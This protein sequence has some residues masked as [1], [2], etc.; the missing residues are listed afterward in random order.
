MDYQCTS[1][2][3][4]FL[5]RLG[6]SC[7]GL[8]AAVLQNSEIF[9]GIKTNGRKKGV[10]ISAGGNGPQEFVYS[11]MVGGAAMGPAGHFRF[12]EQRAIG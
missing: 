5:K 8:I 2:V 3:G 9:N 12:R 7:R 10:R 1:E 6:D 4:I 11:I